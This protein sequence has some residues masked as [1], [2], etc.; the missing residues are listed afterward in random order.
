MEFQINKF[1]SMEDVREQLV[2]ERNF[3]NHQLA[4]M[5]VMTDMWVKKS[6]GYQEERNDAWK[7]IDVLEKH[8]EKMGQTYDQTKNEIL[9]D[10][11]DQK[12]DLA[13]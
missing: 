11:E 9:K 5:K 6:C 4:S 7:K 3:L 8:I 12:A 13:N 10:F 2:E 1:N